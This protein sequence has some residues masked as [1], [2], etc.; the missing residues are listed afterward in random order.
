[1]DLDLILIFLI[2]GVLGVAGMM[3]LDSLSLFLAVCVL[4][5]AAVAVAAIMASDDWGEE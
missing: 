2:V 4:G 1:M 5:V 3:D